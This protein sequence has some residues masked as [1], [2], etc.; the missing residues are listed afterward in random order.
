MLSIAGS[1]GVFRLAEVGEG[2]AL[3]LDERLLA[4]HRAGDTRRLV[5]LYAEAA[6]DAADRGDAEAAAF[7]LTHAYV[8]ALESGDERASELHAALKE[9]G[10]DE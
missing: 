3:L 9:A 6:E 8:F 10:R 4:A 2:G 5:A 1:P 7:Y